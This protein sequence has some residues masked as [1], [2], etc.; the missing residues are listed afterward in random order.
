MANATHATRASN[1]NDRQQHQP[2]TNRPLE[3]IGERIATLRPER[4]L[5]QADLANLANLDQ[6]RLSRIEKGQLLASADVINRTATALELSSGYELAYGTD[7]E[8]AYRRSLSPEDLTSNDQ[9]IKAVRELCLF[10]LQAHYQRIFNA[11]EA[12]YGGEGMVYPVGLLGEALYIQLQANCEK[13]LPAVAKFAPPG[14]E[15]LYFPGH[16]ESMG[17]EDLPGPGDG[18]GIGD[19]AGMCESLNELTKLALEYGYGGPSEE[20]QTVM[21]KVWGFDE[22]DEAIEQARQDR[23]RCEEQWLRQF[24]NGI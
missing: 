21:F 8:E 19:R 10:Y 22:L 15:K 5:S 13:A 9:V 3:P 14:I 24:Q 18:W 17:D 23:V 7:R 1:P 6:P 4:R 2:G 16:L 11:F 20:A 12:L